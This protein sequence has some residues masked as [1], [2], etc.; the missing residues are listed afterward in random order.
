MLKFLK[1]SLTLNATL[2]IGAWIS[3]RWF[4]IYKINNLSDFGLACSYLAC[5]FYFPLFIFFLILIINEA[6]ITQIL[7]YMNFKI[8][9]LPNKVANSRIHNLFL[10]I[11]GF[12]FIII[13]AIAIFNFQHVV[14]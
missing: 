8:K 3:I 14:F 5:F 12:S 4:H 9:L 2:L 7:K 11:T 1:N 13:F 10:L 6:L